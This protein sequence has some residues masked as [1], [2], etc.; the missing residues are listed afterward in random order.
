MGNA[1]D[2]ASKADRDERG[3]AGPLILAVRLR[4]PEQFDTVQ[5]IMT[6]AGAT[7]VNPISR[8]DDLLTAGVSSASWTGN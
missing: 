4:S 1:A 8:G 6:Q 5:T 3:R 2:N 7:S